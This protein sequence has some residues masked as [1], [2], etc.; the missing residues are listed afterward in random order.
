RRAGHA[1]GGPARRAR[2]PGGVAGDPRRPAGSA[3]LDAPAR[4]FS[5]ALRVVADEQPVLI[6]VDDAHWLDRESLLALGA[7]ARDL[8]RSR[9]L[10]LI[11]AA[12]HERREELDQVR[13][14]LGRDLAGTGVTLGPLDADALHALARWGAPSYDAM[15]VERL[16][17]RIVADS[18]GIPLLAVELLNAVAVG[19]DLQAVRGAW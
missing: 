12:P 2:I 3:A 6:V 8:A 5:E 14:H 10:L 19:L 11:T 1:P 15:Q 4:A 9:V 13:A 7:A 16:A 17:R 18:A